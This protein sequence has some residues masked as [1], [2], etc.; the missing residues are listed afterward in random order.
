MEREVF[1]YIEA[2]EKNSKTA[3]KARQIRFATV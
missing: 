3:D 1:S 2:L